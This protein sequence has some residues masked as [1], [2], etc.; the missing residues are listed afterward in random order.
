MCYIT[1]AIC[2]I[3]GKSDD[4]YELQTLRDYRDNWL[5]H[6]M[7]GSEL[8]AEY[9]RTAPALATALHADENRT[10]IADKL[11]QDYLLPCISFIRNNQ[12]EACREHYIHMVNFISTIY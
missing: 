2:E 1:T 8:I 4:C 6:Q 12:P 3:Q 5:Q 11:Y 10:A 9:Y 7:G